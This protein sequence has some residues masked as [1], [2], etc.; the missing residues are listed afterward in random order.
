VV[1]ILCPEFQWPMLQNIITSLYHYLIVTESFI[2]ELISAL[3]AYAPPS[4]Y[5]ILGI[6][7]LKKIPFLAY[8]QWSYTH[9]KKSSLYLSNLAASH[10]FTNGTTSF[11]PPDLGT[12]C[13]LCSIVEHNNNNQIDAT[14][15]F[16]PFMQHSLPHNTRS[17]LPWAPLP[18]SELFNWSM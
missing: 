4:A 7:C 8:I 15:S 2:P 3:V 6:L 11:C 17:M 12:C 10:G 14:E 18:S 5:P 9:L 16:Y 13:H 1:S